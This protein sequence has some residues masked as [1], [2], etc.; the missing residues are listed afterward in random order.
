MSSDCDL[1]MIDKSEEV[2]NGK[3]SEDDACGAQ[4][5]CW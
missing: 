1:R 5:S 3:N 2:A 4:S